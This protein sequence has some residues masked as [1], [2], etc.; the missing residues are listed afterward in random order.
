MD[1]PKVIKQIAKGRN[2]FR[3]ISLAIKQPLLKF[4]NASRRKETLTT[5]LIV[6]LAH[7]TTNKKS[8]TQRHSTSM[9][10]KLQ[11]IRPA[12]K[13]KGKYET[14]LLFNRLARTFKSCT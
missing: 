5:K 2:S 10:L 8:N 11:M 13:L 12:K 4:A 6:C 14:Y 9:K 1:I 7:Y 3:F